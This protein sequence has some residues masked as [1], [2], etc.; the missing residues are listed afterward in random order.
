MGGS[1]MSTL[2]E[3]I[4]RAHRS[5]NPLAFWQDWYRQE[6]EHVFRRS[7][8]FVAHDSLIPN[9]SDYVASYMAE[10]P[11]IVQRGRDG[12]IR[13]HRNPVNGYRLFDRSDLERLLQ[14]I[15]K[16]AKADRYRGSAP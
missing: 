9:N 8:M 5:V 11:V 3:A 2:A 13:V 14:K 15:D 7:W 10:D 6:L 16:S 4:D 12:K 1:A